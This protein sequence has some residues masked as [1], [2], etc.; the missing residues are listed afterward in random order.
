MKVS[1]VWNRLSSV[2]V[3]L[4][5]A[6][7]ALA[8]GIWYLPEIQRNRDLQSERLL[9][10]RQVAAAQAHGDDLRS[11]IRAFSSNPTAAERVIRERFGL[12]KPGELVV[13]FEPPASAPAVAPR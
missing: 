5:F 7:A 10:E 4:I 6:A 1:T 3:V 11:R 13:H 2:V 9:L 8:V 12:A